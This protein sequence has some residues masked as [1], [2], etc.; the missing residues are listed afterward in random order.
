MQYWSMLWTNHLYFS[1]PSVLCFPLPFQQT[2]FFFLFG[3]YLKTKGVCYCVS[4][5]IATNH[6][7]KKFL[8]YCVFYHFT[9]NIYSK[10]FLPLLIILKKW[11][12]KDSTKF[13][14]IRYAFKSR[15]YDEHSESNLWKQN[16]SKIDFFSFTIT[17]CIFNML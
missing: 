17:I 6:F 5:I 10:W 8:K 7:T 9:K 14:I 2:I 1:L 12:M 11:W 3:I 15:E 13:L 4:I 16:T